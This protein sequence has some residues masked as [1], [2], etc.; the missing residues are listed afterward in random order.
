MSIQIKE[1]S[2]ENLIEYAEIPMWLKVTSKYELKEIDGGLGGIIFEEVN[3][4]EYI[5][6][7]A[8]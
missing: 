6:D 1:V 8:K 4:K 7:Y 5:K 2:K 3:V